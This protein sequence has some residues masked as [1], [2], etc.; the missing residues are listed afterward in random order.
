MPD[1]P[2]ALIEARNME[3]RLAADFVASDEV[4]VGE[5]AEHFGGFFG[6]VDAERSPELD[7]PVGSGR[8]V[9]EIVGGQQ[10][11]EKAAAV[12]VVFEPEPGLGFEE[13]ATDNAIRQ[14]SLLGADRALPR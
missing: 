3:I 13:F 7:E 14:T 9:A 12:G 6:V 2:A 1:M 8:H 11:G 5:I 4:D 10:A